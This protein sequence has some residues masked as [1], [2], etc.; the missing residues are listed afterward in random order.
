MSTEMLK[1]H[2]DL[3]SLKERMR[4]TYAYRKTFM[5]TAK[6]EEIIE[7]FPAL[8]LPKILLWE[9]KEQFLVEADRRMVT[10][11]DRMATKT[12][13]RASMCDLKDCCQRAINACLDD[14]VRRGLIRDAA[15]LLLPSIFRE[16][17]SFLYTLLEEPSVPTP[18]IML[19]NTHEGNPLQA[20][21]ITLY[22]DGIQVLTEDSSMDISYAMSAL[23]SLYF[24][25]AVQYPKELRKTLIFIERFVLG[26]KDHSVVPISVKRLYNCV[27]SGE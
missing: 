21:R 15:I 20:Q 2:P 8:K 25:F 19:H 22:L 27:G 11:L 6:A 5:A 13:Q 17:S 10:E 9:M 1:V 14:S 18:A 3:N 12:V 23:M 4:R 24:V 16:D 7:K 26:I